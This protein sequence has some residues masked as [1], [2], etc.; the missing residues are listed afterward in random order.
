MVRVLVVE[1][2]PVIREFLTYVLTRD[3][4]I[5]VV[6]TAAN[7]EEAIEAA[8][9]FKPEVITMDIHMPKMDGFE[10]T[11]RIMEK[12]PTPIIIVS[13]SST[14]KE[15][16]LTFR[17]L[18]SGALTVAARP[19]GI[20]H[21]DHEATSRELV[22]TVKL[23]S[24]VKVVRRW[25]NIS[26][27]T[28]V[29]TPSIAKVELVPAEIKAVAIGGSTGAPLVIKTILAGLPRPF[30]V[31]ILVV[32]HIAGGFVQGFVEWLSSVTGFSVRIAADGEVLEPDKAYVAPDGRHMGVGPDNRIVLS[33][34]DAEFGLRPAVAFL[35][36]SVARVYGNKTAAVLLTGMGKDGAAELKILKDKGAITIVQ[37]KETSLIYGMPGEAVKLEA[38]TYILPPEKIAGVLAAL[39]NK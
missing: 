3:K 18:E 20:G 21:P 27:Y 30:P 16:S 36:R 9:L 38:A 1:D 6:G 17:A 29:T 8:I 13:G 23:M 11:R 7:G 24:E 39:V 31:P 26:K 10:A 12:Q 4:S 22:Q 35:F 34:D 19:K 5:E 2:S 14:A 15:T 37:D 28:A 33:K 32:Q 25:R